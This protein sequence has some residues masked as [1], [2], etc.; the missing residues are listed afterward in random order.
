M[1]VECR[2]PDEGKKMRAKRAPRA[3]TEIQDTRKVEDGKWGLAFSLGNL[4]RY[5][6]MSSEG[7]VGPCDMKRTEWDQ[8]FQEGSA[9]RTSDV[10][11]KRSPEPARW[12]GKSP[13]TDVVR[14]F[15]QFFPRRKYRNRKQGGRFS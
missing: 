6:R 13:S 11:T 14:Y 1:I 10:E 5:L 9:G 2:L 4:Q 15:V 7:G 3:S 8:T 12:S